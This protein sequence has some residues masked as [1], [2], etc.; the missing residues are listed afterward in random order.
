MGLIGTIRPANL[1]SS[2]M[3]IA[4]LPRFEASRDAPIIATQCG[5]RNVFKSCAMLLT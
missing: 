4:R 3:W 2:S 1:E 5:L